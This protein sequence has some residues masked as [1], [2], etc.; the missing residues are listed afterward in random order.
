MLVVGKAVV[1]GCIPDNATERRVM[2]AANPWEQVVLD[3][4]VQPADKPVQRL[5]IPGEVGGGLHLSDHPLSTAAAFAFGMVIGFLDH[6]GQLEH[7]AQDRPR[8][9]MHG[10]PADQELPPGHVQNHQW[11][12]DGPQIAERLR[13]DQGGPFPGLVGQ[14]AIGAE[15]TLDE[16]FV[17]LGQNPEQRRQR[18]GEEGVEVLEP[19]DR[20]PLTMRRQPQQRRDRQVLIQ[21]VDIGMSVMDRIVGDLPH[22]A[23]GATQIEG[24][25]QQAVDPGRGTIGPVQRVMRHRET[26]PRDAHADQR[27]QTQHLPGTKGIGQQQRVGPDR[28]GQNDCRLDHHAHVGVLRQIAFGEIGRDTGLNIRNEADSVAL[29]RRRS[30]HVHYWSSPS[31]VLATCLHC[32]QRK[33][34]RC[35]V[36]MRS[37]LVAVA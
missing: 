35:F 24:E 1:A 30:T 13:P 12:D 3:L 37:Q 11:H 4:E 36:G 27:R 26:D 16:V 8:H 7:H 21:S 19:V 6:V 10:Q 33:G 14:V 29:D 22:V 32:G 17:V 28:D 2:H 18:I 9:Q 31:P 34:H 25:P 23:I 5:I 15:V 20:L